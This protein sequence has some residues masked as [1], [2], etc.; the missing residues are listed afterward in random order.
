MSQSATSR[1]FGRLKDT[2]QD[3]LL[4]RTPKG[5]KLSIKAE[6]IYPEL[7]NIISN[8][9]NI[10]EEPEFDPKTTNE[11]IRFFGVDLEIISYLPR[12]FS[13][14]QKKAPGLQL[15]VFTGTQDHFSLLK[16][17]DVD[18]SMSGMQPKVSDEGL[19]RALLSK[20]GAICV[21]RKNHPLANQNLTLK[22]YLL[23][24]HGIINLT[25]RGLGAIDKKLKQ[26]G[27][28][29]NISIRLPN[30]TSAA[31]FCETSDV[32]FLMPNNIANQ[33]VKRHKLITKPLPKELGTR[34][35]QFYIYWHKNNHS[36]PLSVWIRNEIKAAL[37]ET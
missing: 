4:I 33:I 12:L 20:E 13:Q 28:K 29:R 19:H 9:H 34:Q 8:I 30:F 35:S 15:S 26:L 22:K 7:Q 11:V 32:I 36:N 23:C 25:G 37:R 27:H 1:A 31:Y 21:M 24:H 16:S 14:I 2:F 18:F 5:Y 6:S 10:I 3:P 17:G